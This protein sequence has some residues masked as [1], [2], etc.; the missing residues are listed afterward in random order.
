MENKI[1]QLF[2]E[3]LENH[4]IEPHG[5][6]WERVMESV[7]HSKFQ[8]SSLSF[9]IALKIAAALL[10][11]GFFIGE[12]NR[13]DTI[14]NTILMMNPNNLSE[15]PLVNQEKCL[16][17]AVAELKNPVAIKSKR[18]SRLI[19][20]NP[21]T[22]MPK[23][24]F[25][26]IPSPEVYVPSTLEANLKIEEPLPSI[27]KVE[28]Q[29]EK[30]TM[31]IVYSLP[32]VETKMEEP[33]VEPSTLKKVLQFAQDVKSGDATLASVRIFKNPFGIEVPELN[34]SKNN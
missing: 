33:K 20:T 4:S 18:N 12:V 13:T 22:N 3:K 2:R 30:K 25:T 21:S 29:V 5:F 28:K 9:S 24:K 16:D 23:S 15:M 6:A 32:P 8:H 26:N 11:M 10:F 17:K 19:K 31:V 1:D 14:G 7:Q 27:A 34:Q